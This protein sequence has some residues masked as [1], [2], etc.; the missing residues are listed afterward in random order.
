MLFNTLDRGQEEI[1]GR[2]ALTRQTPNRLVGI[3]LQL[4]RES[5]K[6]HDILEHRC[7]SFPPGHESPR[8]RNFR[9]SRTKD[10]A[11]KF[12]PK[13]ERL[14]VNSVSLHKIFAENHIPHAIIACENWLA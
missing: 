8:F 3:A 2:A 1:R 11:H 9:V 13:R 6:D 12:Y 10:G 7:L 14:S 5:R 4:S